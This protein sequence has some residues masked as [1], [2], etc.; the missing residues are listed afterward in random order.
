MTGTGLGGLPAR[1]T[2]PGEAEG[3]AGHFEGNIRNPALWMDGRGGGG[4]C[5][6]VAR[7]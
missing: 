3:R 2:C 6:N 4:G 1:S 7:C 5:P